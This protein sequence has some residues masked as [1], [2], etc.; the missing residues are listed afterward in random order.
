MLLVYIFAHPYL[1]PFPISPPGILDSPQAPSYSL[2]SQARVW[3]P[4]PSFLS[5]SRII[6]YFICMLL[7][8][9]LSNLVILQVYLLYQ[10]V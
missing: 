7:C 3:I 5:A 8:N 6:I 10:G 1:I 4:L 2:S 9:F